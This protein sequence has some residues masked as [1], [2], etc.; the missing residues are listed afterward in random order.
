MLR[1]CD[2]YLLRETVGP[3]FLALAGLVLFILL[4]II[5]SLSDLMVDRGV[6]M[7][8]LL[9]LVA[10]KIPNLLIVAVP[11]SAL[12]ATFLGLGRMGHD[13]EI[14]AY[15]SI[16]IP[17]R[18]VLLPLLA[19]ALVVSV[20]DFA[21]Y[22]WLVP[23]SESAYEQQLQDIIFREGIPR[24]TS[25]TFFRSQDDQYFYIRRYDEETGHLYD[26][27]IYDTTG[28]L[29]PQAGTRITQITA[30]EGLWTGTGWTLLVGNVYGFDSDGKLAYSGSY[31][32]LEIPLD[33]TVQQ[34]MSYQ[35]S[36]TQ[37]SLGKLQ[38][39]IRQARLN[40]QD[41]S[42]YV[43]EKHLKLSLPLATLVFALFG[44]AISLAYGARSRAS[45]IVIGLLVVALFQGLLWWTQTLGRRGAMN[46]ALA[47]WLPDVVFGILGLV[48]YLNV[49]RL[50][51][52]DIWSKIRSRIPFL[53]LVVFFVCAGAFS[54]LAKGDLPIVITCDRL[55]VS[56]DQCRY[57]AEGAVSLAFEDASLSADAVILEQA[58]D[59]DWILDADGSV[60]LLYGDD[61]RIAGDT[62]RALLAVDE[63]GTSVVPSEVAAS[64]FAGQFAFT[65]SEGESHTLYF[66]GSSGVFSFSDTGETERIE[67][68]DALITTC[69]CCGVSLVGQ[70]Y[71]LQTTR[72]VLYPDQLLTAF[73]LT[74]RIAG[75]RVFWL[76]VYVQP[77]EETL[78]NPL[79]PAIGKSSVHGWFVKWNVPI[80]LSEN[81]Y[82]SVLVDVYTRYMELALGGSLYYDVG[83]HSGTASVYV[84]PAK[85]GDR[86]AE[87]S[88]E[89]SVKLADGWEG[90]ASLKYE[91]NGEDTELSYAT[92]V[93]GRLCGTDVSIA[94]SREQ[95]TDEDEE[96]VVEQQ[97]PEITLDFPKMTI[98]SVV[99]QPS[100]SA[101]WK[102][103]WEGGDPVE[104]A[105]RASGE[106]EL[107]GGSST[108]ATFIVSSKAN[109]EGTVYYT[110][111]AWDA[112]VEASFSVS[113]GNGPLRLTWTSTLV[114]GSSPFSSDQAETTHTL[115][116]RVQRDGD[117]SV[118][119]SGVI[120]LADGFEPIDL[121]VTWGKN[122]A[123]RVTGD[124]EPIDGR[125]TSVAAYGRWAIDDSRT[126]SWSI[127]YDVDNRK[128]D[129]VSL[130]AKFATERSELSV[131][132]E[133]DLNERRLE[134]TDVDL[135][136]SLE[137][138]W[139][140]TVSASYEPAS[141]SRP[142]TIRYGV[143][144]DIADCLR[145]G[146]E[147]T[148]TEVWLYASV[149]AFPEA[150][151]RYAP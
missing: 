55:T 17:L 151:L 46:P 127:P 121:R 50:A 146:V 11:M 130:D 41:V 31:E 99:A 90:T 74:A 40:G 104:E 105:F 132:N 76:P 122:V 60:S 119:L 118:R 77:L 39:L 6:G 133:I 62:L 27:M 148:R 134:S 43:V 3:F 48:L 87:A 150:V 120:D 124:L 26:V 110:E 115:D 89:H 67:V 100:F 143:Y 107:D 9:R 97:I 131:S 15:E 51:S 128:F 32:S 149:L 95:E 18:R 8:D 80:F 69:N 84:F 42:E 68:L 21:V 16:G 28:R 47:A 38:A 98:G 71:S 5:L 147:K 54:C 53:S 64:G 123:W 23:Q 108:V 66:Q 137:S 138:P 92:G 136:L 29:F 94:I 45:G 116:W 19:A 65:N 75:V 142:L 14:I 126:I 36:P 78:D 22:N 102:Q 59:G 101:G 58:D 96:T 117:I 79:F 34:I 24:I 86:E 135:D 33:Q 72:V 82:G 109:V 57:L 10:F 125:V 91:R 139:G 114:S 140:I 52:R 30:E 93:E 35:L 20:A 49:D 13:R 12:F 144:Y 4:N 73:G 56:D 63:S 37:L 85:V 111:A 129:T 103:E 70:P 2:R 141:G 83:L 61:V 81:V 7:L 112:R 113:A 25:N 106:L 44:G 1:R 145:I 88:L